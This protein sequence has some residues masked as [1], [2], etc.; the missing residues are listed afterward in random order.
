M[1]TTFKQVLTGAIALLLIAAAGCGRSPY[2]IDKAAHDA[3]IAAW[4]KTRLERLT[5]ETGWLTL[6]GLF[7]LKEG[8]NGL[9]CDSSNAIIFPAG[10]APAHAGTLTLDHG[11]VTLQALPGVEMRHNDSLV[12]AIVMQSDARADADPTIITLGR[13]TFQIIDRA[14][15]LG[16]RVKNKDNPVRTKFAGL[17]YFPVDLKWRVVAKF[18][19][20]VPH[21]VLKIP[22]MI[23]TVE[24]DS[25]PGALAFELDGHAYRIDAVIEQGAEDRL[26]LMIG[27]ATNGHETYGPGRQLYT[28]LPDSAGNVV[29]DFNKAYNWPCVFT[30]YATC[31]IPPRQNVLPV[32]IEAGEKMYAGHN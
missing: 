5:S 22:T 27:D 2:A 32:R 26:F 20:Y 21:K 6:C 25:C 24:E 16:V 28:A 13:L 23:N 4:K 3:E 30:V 11:V 12:S 17:D 10:T 15:Q 31:P 29:I 1:T 18:E 7:W 14:G 9:G 8:A 19:P